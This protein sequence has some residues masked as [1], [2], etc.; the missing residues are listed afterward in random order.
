M[1]NKILALSLSAIICSVYFSNISAYATDLTATGKCGENLNWILT[2]D[3]ILTISGKGDMYNYNITTKE[4]WNNYEQ[5][6]EVVITNGVTSIGDYAFYESNIEKITFAD[7]IEII[8]ESAFMNSTEVTFTELPKNL[9]EI[10]KQAFLS[11]FNIPEHLDLPEHLN[12]IGELA[13]GSGLYYYH[14]FVLDSIYIPKNIN[15]I[16]D[17]SLGAVSVDNFLEVLDKYFE[18]GI[19]TPP[20]NELFQYRSDFIIYGYKNTMAEIYAEKNN[21]NFIALDLPGDPNQDG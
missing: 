11:C 21:L 4:N 15:E 12:K 9:K 20:V 19:D 10:K 3:G 6:K 17:F 2:D 8:G 14:T 13:F 16:E 7:T 5:I 1:K 18:M